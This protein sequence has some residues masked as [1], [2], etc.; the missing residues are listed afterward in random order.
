MGDTLIKL[1]LYC[2]RGSYIVLMADTL[3]KLKLH[4]PVVSYLVLM[5]M[6]III[7]VKLHCPSDKGYNDAPHCTL[8]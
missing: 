3:T 6:Y 5:T 8:S 7:K 4:C 2:P 1:K